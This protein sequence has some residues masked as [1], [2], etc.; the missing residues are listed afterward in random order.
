MANAVDSDPYI[1]LETSKCV[2]IPKFR[3]N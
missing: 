1:H 2:G 3:W